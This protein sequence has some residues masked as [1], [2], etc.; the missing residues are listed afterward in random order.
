MIGRRIVPFLFC[1]PLL[2]SGCS[3]EFGNASVEVKSVETGAQQN[4]LSTTE[5]IEKLKT[6]IKELD[7]I[8]E[9]YRSLNQELEAERLRLLAENKR[10]VF[11]QQDQT[12]SIDQKDQVAV[13]IIGKEVF[14]PQ[15]G[16]KTYSKVPF[17]PMTTPS[18]VDEVKVLKPG[19]KLQFET[20]QVSKAGIKAY[21]KLGDQSGWIPLWYLTK[22][23]QTVQSI[24]ESSYNKGLY[25]KNIPLY[26]YPNAPSYNGG[27]EMSGEITAY[28]VAK[29]GNWLQIKLED[30]E[31][32]YWIEEEQL[33]D[34]NTG[35][36]M[37]GLILK[38]TILYEKQ[39][40]T[41]TPIQKSGQWPVSVIK[42]E[43][44]YYLISGPGVIKY[45][46]K[47]ADFKIVDEAKD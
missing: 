26:L 5:E 18:L 46:I 4:I 12:P 43:G 21:V 44:D 10:L 14:V 19:T 36:I 30:Q 11:N 37:N 3:K 29:W 8:T 23:S 2:L 13:G 39:G 35:V 42:K 45:Y 33:G 24:E 1:A 38:D 27:K 22:E 34:D 6:R 20:C 47:K 25:L 16:Y 15:L 7:K 40:Q 9:T 32:L 17:Y 31:V 41:Y 28:Q